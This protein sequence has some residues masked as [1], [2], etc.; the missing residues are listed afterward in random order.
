[1][2]NVWLLACGVALGLAALAPAI[3]QTESVALPFDAAK[4]RLAQPEAN[5][6]A[7]V[8]F[9]EDAPEG[10][11]PFIVA[12]INASAGGDQKALANGQFCGGSLVAPRWGAAAAHCVTRQGTDGKSRTVDL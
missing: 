6:E 9:G 12:L 10:A 11:Y 7:R 2:R 3:A 8:F 5:R 4:S 1:M